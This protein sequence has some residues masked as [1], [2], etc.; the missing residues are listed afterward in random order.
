MFAWCAALRAQQ[1]DVD[2]LQVREQ[3][4]VGEGGFST[5]WRVHLVADRGP[6]DERLPTTMALKKTI[7]QDEERLD[8]AR[9]EV[10]LLKRASSEGRHAGREFLVQ[11]FSHKELA[12]QKGGNAM[13]E[14]QLLMEWCGGGSLLSRILGP[15]TVAIARCPNMPEAEVVPVMREAA[16]G[17]AFLH[18]LG[19]VHYDLKPENI[20]FNEGHVRL[21]DFGSASERQWPDFGPDAS[22][23][24]AREVELFF[25]NRTT[26]M[27][28][29]PELADPDLVRLPVTAAADL[30]MLGLCLYQMLFAVH[31]FPL[32]GR[33]AN[34]HVRYVLPEGAETCY[35]PALLSTLAALLSRDPL[36]RPRG[37]VI[38]GIGPRSFRALGVRCPSSVPRAPSS[39]LAR[40]PS[41]GG[42]VSVPEQ[43][44]EFTRICQKENEVQM[45]TAL[46]ELDSEGLQLLKAGKVPELSHQLFMK[47]APDLMHPR[48]KL[49]TAGQD[50]LQRKISRELPQRVAAET[51]TLRKQ[52]DAEIRERRRLFADLRQRAKTAASAAVA[53]SA[54]GPVR[55]ATRFRPLEL[56]RPP[57]REFPTWPVTKRAVVG[58]DR[59]AS[60]LATFRML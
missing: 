18:S 8:L 59:S 57:T 22:R 24:A 14:V 19:I 38:L 41:L 10:E 58:V 7:C 23:R 3:G 34:I 48:G 6:D 52:I 40:L 28:R 2:G 56:S 51:A 55:G 29:P 36:Q 9:N 33:L 47:S 27:F 35:S 42:K 54:P 16:L 15:E 11:Y 44:A 12:C 5:I 50:L 43:C 46:R 21:C 32:E 39:D 20:L 49:Q 31:A 17:L 45:Q 4:Q 60:D 37:E 25:S 30:F 53:R 13:T 1:H 26:P